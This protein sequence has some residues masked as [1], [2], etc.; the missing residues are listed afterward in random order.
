MLAIKHKSKKPK[1]EIFPQVLSD[2]AHLFQ[3]AYYFLLFSQQEEP[4]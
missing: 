4:E 3:Q 2:S 1:N